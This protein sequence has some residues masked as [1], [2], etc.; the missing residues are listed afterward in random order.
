M[1]KEVEII[2]SN[3]I[4]NH[5]VVNGI[6][7]AQHYDIKKGLDSLN[8][9]LNKNDIHIDTIIEIGTYRGGFT[10]LLNSH[11]IS[12]NAQIH[13]FDIDNTIGQEKVCIH[14][15]KVSFYCQNV[16][17]NNTIENL[18]SSSKNNV[19]VFCDGGNKIEEFNRYSYNLRVNDMIFAHDYSFSNE[20]F[21]SEIRGKIW[22]YVECTYLDIKDSIESNNL[23][24][25]TYMENVVWASYI[26]RKQND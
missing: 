7:T 19:L 20:I 23:K 12:T 25:L 8:S 21:N 11:D 26:K 18:I 4:L 16:F 22:D 15:D 6:F 10:T 24:R 3:D 9:Y 5:C 17:D 13:T 1:S 14:L 2:K